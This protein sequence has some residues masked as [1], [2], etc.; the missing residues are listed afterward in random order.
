MGRNVVYCAMSLDGFI[1]RRDGDVRWLAAAG[2]GSEEVGDVLTFA[3]FLRGVGAIVMG[4]RSFDVVRSF[5][6]S[7]WP[8]GETPLLVAT[9]R[10][11]AEDGP[12]RVQ[13]VRGDIGALCA[14]ARHIAGDADVYIDGGDIVSQALDANLIDALWVTQAPV[15]LGEGVRLYQGA[16][17]HAFHAQPLGSLRGMSQILLRPR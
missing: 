5:G 13:A 6:P 9:R 4:R 15:L 7:V 1:A 3:A 8:Y 14:Q 10:P 17:L 12:G 11:L 2:T 16:A